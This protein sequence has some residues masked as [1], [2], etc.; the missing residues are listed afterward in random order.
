MDR[1]PDVR[2][3]LK[4]IKDL[5]KAWLALRASSWVYT[6]ADQE[7]QDSMEWDLQCS[8]ICI[9]K[10]V[11]RLRKHYGFVATFDVTVTGGTLEEWHLYLLA[12]KGTETVTDMMANLGAEP[13]KETFADL[14][15]QVHSGWRARLS[16]TDLQQ[17][18]VEAL[19]SL[20]PSDSKDVL[21]AGHSLGGALAQICMLW[22]WKK[23]V[24]VN[25]GEATYRDVVKNARCFTFGS[26]APFANLQLSVDA[27]C[28][29][30]LRQKA[31]KWLAEACTN[32][33]H[34]KDPVVRL[35][36]NVEALRQLAPQSISL[37]SGLLNFAGITPRLPKELKSYRPLCS[38]IVLFWPQ[39]SEDWTTLHPV[40]D[41]ERYYSWLFGEPPDGLDLQVHNIETYGLLFH[42]KPREDLAN[43]S[44]SMLRHYV[45]SLQAVDPKLERRL[46]RLAR[47]LQRFTPSAREDLMAPY[48]HMFRLVSQIQAGLA[49][50]QED[51]QTLRHLGHEWQHNR[52]R[53]KS[54][55]EQLDRNLRSA[56]ASVK[57]LSNGTDAAALETTRELSRTFGDISNIAEEVLSTL[58]ACQEQA[59]DSLQH[60]DSI[61]T[62]LQPAIQQAAELKTAATAT[63]SILE[64]FRRYLASRPGVRLVTELGVTFALRAATGSGGLA[65]AL[66]YAALLAMWPYDD[67]L[68]VHLFEISRGLGGYAEC[69]TPELERM[70]AFLRTFREKLVDTQTGQE[71]MQE[72]IKNLKEEMK[73]LAK[74]LQVLDQEVGSDERRMVIA[75]IT[76]AAQLMLEKHE[77][78]CQLEEEKPALAV[79][80][81]LAVMS[82]IPRALTAYDR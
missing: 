62:K 21:V 38:M 65:C 30:A 72:C 25:G 63:G 75:E 60:V 67:E 11:A 26:P 29:D 4:E 82:A 73:V 41:A 77:E 44:E 16:D 69:V 51:G 55:M 49:E 42:G 54:L 39:P 5:L 43:K 23:F 35:P 81:Q 18:L 15:M 24:N 64:F 10:A 2:T 33:A 37:G 17:K 57:L 47:T 70:D 61:F 8:E 58:D 22:L 50:M 12:F 56:D 20:D 3:Q 78:A 79:E 27:H 1:R 48:S 68:L 19:Q 74:N 45:V 59:K 34:V 52:K 46:S 9:Y 53:L 76:N 71:E 6:S 36:F 80:P 13:C 28:R 7:Q 66:A 31:Q 14:G 40:D 32:I